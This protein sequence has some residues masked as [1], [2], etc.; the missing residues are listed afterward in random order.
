MKTEGVSRIGIIGNG[1]IGDSLSV[2]TTG[3]GCTT[4]CLARNAEKIPEY[5]KAY[6]A[7]FA[8]MAEHGVITEEGIKNSATYLH[9]STNYADLADCELIFEC[10]IEDIALKQEIYAQIETTCPNV[11]VICSVSSSF[12][13]DVLCEKAGIYKDRIIVTHPFHPAHMIPFVEICGSASTAPGVMEFAKTVLESLDRKPVILKKPAPGFIGNRLQFAMWREALNIMES[14]IADPRDID[15]CLNYSFCP[16]YTSVGMFEHF[17]SGGL[18][19]N[20]V[21]CDTV[22]PTLSDIDAAPPAITDRIAR[23]DLG[24][25]A[26]IGFYD[27]RGADLNAYRER[28]VAPYW[29]FAHW[30]VPQQGEEPKE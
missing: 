1:M 8:Q 25:K 12:V 27:W 21:T 4:I 22:F 26:G 30:D 24:I 13:P 2:L 16:R 29:R 19:L 18:D 20:I 3:H 7:Y 14:G 11:R 10:V 5:R 28:V 9:Y 15:T 17:D 6:D 23:G